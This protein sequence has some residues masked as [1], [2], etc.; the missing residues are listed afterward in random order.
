MELSDILAAT[1]V[2][3][4]I[5]SVW[6]SYRA[7]RESTQFAEREAQREFFRERSEFLIR[8]ERSIKLFERV[9]TRILGILA[10]IENEAGAVQSSRDEVAKQL[11]ADLSYLQGCLCQSSSLW[12]ENYEISQDGF[13]HHKP[14]HLALLEDDEKFAHEAMI[15]ADKAEESFN[16][17]AFLTNPIVG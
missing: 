6:L 16:L 10:S 3:V 13:V 17:S 9:E 2:V 5:F 12:N 15:R 8:I 7:H 1:A 11:K 4:S 14:R